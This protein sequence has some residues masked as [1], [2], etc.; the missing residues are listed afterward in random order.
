MEREGAAGS[1]PDP[2]ASPIPSAYNDAVASAEPIRIDGAMGEGGGQIVRSA[3]ALSLV[4]GRPFAL[5]NIRAGRERPG[6]LRQHL[7]AL[8]AAAAV[9]AAEFDGGS[10]GSRELRFAPRRPR[11]GSY[12]FA[13]GSAGST[14]LVLQTVLPALLLADGP[15]ELVL[16][17]GTHN[18]F[19]PP[20]DFLDRVLVP[21]LNRMG[22][23]VRTRI[24]R[25]GFYPA[26]GGI[27]RV[28]VAPAS[29]LA[30]LELLERGSVLARRAVARVSRLPRHIAERELATVGEALALPAESRKVEEVRDAAGP[31]NV[32]L[33]EIE[34]EHLIEL[35]TGFGR[36][37]ISAEQV[38][39][40][41]SREVQEYLD[42]GAPVG[43]HLADQLLVPVALAGGGSYRT[44]Q[45]TRH[46]RTNIEVVRTFLDIDIGIRQER[47]GVF[48]VAIG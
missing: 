31:G 4:T 41:L 12:R 42:S 37:G 8:E 11:A 7:A 9:S 17:G 32:L 48:T 47:R 26:G 23:E 3:L 24:E 2:A 6:L 45:P 13:I 25:P 1:E 39:L 27:L 21:L 40:D 29:R 44:S 18:P 46:T 34:S 33:V 16:E 35:F 43:P 30:R 38:A 14:T 19:A 10:L 36:R 22:P 28:S 15:S 20:F 5:R